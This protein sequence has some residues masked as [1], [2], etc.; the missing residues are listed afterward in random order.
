MVTEGNRGL[1]SARFAV[2]GVTG[3]RPRAAQTYHDE[4]APRSS[5]PGSSTGAS[6]YSVLTMARTVPCVRSGAPK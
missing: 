5:F 1:A 3:K 4:I 6:A 2:P